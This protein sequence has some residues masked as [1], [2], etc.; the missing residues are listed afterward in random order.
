M[1]FCTAFRYHRSERTRLPWTFKHR[2]SFRWRLFRFFNS[3]FN[4]KN[5][6][7]LPSPY[8]RR[9]VCTH[10]H[11]PIGV[12]HLSPG[13]EVCVCVGGHHIAASPRPNTNIGYRASNNVRIISKII[14]RSVRKSDL[15]RWS[16]SESCPSPPQMQLRGNYI[17]PCRDAIGTSG[18]QVSIWNSTSWSRTR[19]RTV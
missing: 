11:T 6:Q 12:I 17:A 18:N 7:G 19:T 8:F 5:G 16:E 15:L 10:K 13:G 1:C 4:P 14:I 2:C 9:T 3:L